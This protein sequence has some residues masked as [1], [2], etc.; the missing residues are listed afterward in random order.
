[1]MVIYKYFPFGMVT[2]QGHLTEPR[3]SRV[4]TGH[5][6]RRDPYGAQGEDLILGRYWF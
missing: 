4:A 2:F 1:M 3:L 5:H 6:G